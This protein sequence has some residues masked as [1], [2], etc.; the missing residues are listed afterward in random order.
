MLCMCIMYACQI[1]KG[2][3]YLI[4]RRKDGR[5]QSVENGFWQNHIFGESVISCVSQ[6]TRIHHFDMYFI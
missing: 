5:R 6:H 2:V 3:Q 1:G 4:M